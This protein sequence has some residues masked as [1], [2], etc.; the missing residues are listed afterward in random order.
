M[1]KME[2][3]AVAVTQTQ[4]GVTTPLA[5]VQKKK[6]GKQIMYDRMRMTCV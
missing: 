3:G 1:I 4:T 2:N 6:Q 5:L